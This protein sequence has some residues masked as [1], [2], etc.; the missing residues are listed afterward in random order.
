MHT[1]A[2]HRR[3]LSAS[4]RIAPVMLFLSGVI[5]VAGYA[6]LREWSALRPALA[7]LTTIW[8]TAGAVAAVCSLWL[9]M[10][11]GDPRPARCGGVAAIVA[12]VTLL[13]AVVLRIA[14]CSGPK[15]VIS[16]LT[17]AAGLMLFGVLAPRTVA[18]SATR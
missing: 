11:G 14:P 17:I 7:A 12:G 2:E 13:I 18:R 10:R 4:I 15:C 8:V 1:I 3:G 16:R 6:Y 9:L 5:L